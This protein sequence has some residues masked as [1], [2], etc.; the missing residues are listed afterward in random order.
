MECDLEWGIAL[1]NRF[2]KHVK[3]LDTTLR[4]GEQTPGVSLVPENKLRIAQRLDE[5]GVDIIEAGFAAVSEGEMEAVSLIAKQKL[6]AQIS[7]AARGTINDID[8][9]LKSG[10][11]TISMIIPTSDLHIQC[12]LHKTREQMLK[13][14][15][16]CITYAKD[17]GLVVELLAE[18]ATRTDPNYLNQFFNAAVEAKADRLI[19]CDTVGILTPE[20]SAELFSKLKENFKIP[21]GVHCH[22]DFGMARC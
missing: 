16:E 4:D 18:D 22:N 11:S 20:R 19:V 7:S 1:F 13:V 14:A 15:D 8:A 9:V 21:I 3:F 5:L 2:P 6:R 17:H 12:K 10:A